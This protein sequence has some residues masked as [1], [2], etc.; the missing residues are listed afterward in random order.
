LTLDTFGGSIGS[1][2]AAAGNRKEYQMRRRTA[3]LVA[4]LTLVVSGAGASVAAASAPPNPVYGTSGA[5]N[6]VNPNA[7]FGMLTKA[8]QGGPGL[9]GMFTAIFNTTGVQEGACP[10]LG[11]P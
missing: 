8:V 2:A 4:A 1:A 9:A 3:V 10:I 6:M 5:C 11:G 7:Q